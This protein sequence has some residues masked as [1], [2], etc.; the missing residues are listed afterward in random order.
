MPALV[1]MSDSFEGAGM[2]DGSAIV[3]PAVSDTRWVPQYLDTLTHYLKVVSANLG[4]LNTVQ[5]LETA[6]AV[7]RVVVMA[8]LRSRWYL[9]VAHHSR[10]SLNCLSNVLGDHCVGMALEGHWLTA[11]RSRSLH[12]IRV[13]ARGGRC[14]REPRISLFP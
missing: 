7:S 9:F 4:R 5:S 1:S 2:T 10:G 8:A 11:M 14:S 6:T 13:A 3:G 12:F